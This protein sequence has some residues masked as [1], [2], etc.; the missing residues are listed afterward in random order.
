MTPVSNDADVQVATAE[1]ID[2]AIKRTLDETGL[3]FTE[4]KSQA[5]SGRF[6]SDR[7]RRAWFVVAPVARRG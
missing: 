1:E 4:L 6:T 3:S 7:A 5:A 2:T